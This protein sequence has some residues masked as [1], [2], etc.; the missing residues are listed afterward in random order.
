MYRGRGCYDK[1]SL[2]ANAKQS[3]KNCHPELDSGS[4]NAD[5]SVGKQEPSPAFVTFAHAHE[6]LL[7]QHKADRVTRI[8]QLCGSLCLTKREGNRTSV[9]DMNQ[10]IFTDKVYS[11]FT[12]HHSLIHTDTNFSLLTKSCFYF[13]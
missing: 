3:S 13:I 11:L 4:I 8:A 6:Q 1:S 10:N 12:T 2:R 9:G 7:P 5:L